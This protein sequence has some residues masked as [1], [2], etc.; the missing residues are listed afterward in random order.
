MIKRACLLLFVLPAL[1]LAGC[2]DDEDTEASAADCEIVGGTDADAAAEVHVTL[3][4]WSIDAD[5]RTVGA[6]TVRFEATNDGVEPHELVLVR[7]A[8]PDEL[9]ITA[10]GLDEAALPEGAVVLGE[11]EG[12]PSGQTCAGT[13]QLEAGAYALVCNIVEAGEHEA[14]AQMGMVAAFT[15][16]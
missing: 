15:V 2:G 7:G 14:H 13:F 16:T 3:D 1:L 5:A 12:F 11:I 10:D 8:D 4:E 6:G 9:T